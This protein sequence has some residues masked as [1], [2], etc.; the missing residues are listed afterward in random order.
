MDTTKIIGYGGR[1]AG[2]WLAYRH[3]GDRIPGGPI[4][5]ALAGWIVGGLLADNLLP[6]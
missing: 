1:A 3:L 6:R 2:A 5:A 4:V